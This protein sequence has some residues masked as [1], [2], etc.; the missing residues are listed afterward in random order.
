MVDISAVLKMLMKV[1]LV[2]PDPTK[3]WFPFSSHLH[4]E[5]RRFYCWKRD[6]ERTILRHWHPS[7]CLALCTP[8]SLCM[9][10][11]TEHCK[12][13]ILSSKLYWL[14][15]KEINDTEE[16]RWHVN[17]ELLALSTKKRRRELF[18]KL[19]SLRVPDILGV[20]LHRAGLKDGSL[21]QLARGQLQG[22][23]RSHLLSLLTETSCI[24]HGTASIPSLSNW[25]SQTLQQGSR[26][27]PR[28]CPR[29]IHASWGQGSPGIHTEGNTARTRVLLM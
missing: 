3:G 8:K 2:F 26:T 10:T 21:K 12:T 29:W 11:L 25:H 23:N 20:N 7:A 4:T 9:K 18:T 6:L 17:K 16:Q 13:Q 19:E 1:S 22:M 28:G 14:S 5:N 27:T 24:Q 15:P